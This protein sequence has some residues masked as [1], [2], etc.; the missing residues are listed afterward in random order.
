MS[1]E[2]PDNSVKK[3]IQQLKNTC[4][5]TAGLGAETMNWLNTL[6]GAISAKSEPMSD[7]KNLADIG[8]LLTEQNA[9][10]FEKTIEQMNGG[11]L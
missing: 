6:F 9:Y 5:D 8:Y 11:E 10:T 2:T 4:I 1:K 7:I 3:T